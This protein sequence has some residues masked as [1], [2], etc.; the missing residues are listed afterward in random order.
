MIY[1]LNKI[2]EN[3]I[4]ENYKQIKA[5]CKENR[6][7]IF[8]RNE[9]GDTLLHLA[10]R[11]ENLDAVKKLMELGSCPILY[12]YSLITPINEAA[13]C[14]DL[15]I[16][17]YLVDKTNEILTDDEKAGVLAYAVADGKVENAKHL[18]KTGFKCNVLYND[19]PII[20]WAIQSGRLE[21]IELLSE[22]G[23]DLN[24]TDDS[25][26]TALYNACANG[27][28]D[29]V[30]FLLSK[31]VNINITS[32][33]G[34]SPLCIASC[35]NQIDIVKLLLKHNV[36]IEIM[37]ENGMTALLYAVKYENIEI[38][39]LLLKHGANPI[40]TDSKGRSWKGVEAFDQSWETDC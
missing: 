40:E 17:K 21:I 18:L 1:D 13:R 28:L 4:K 25:G 33:D 15:E 19:D 7:F 16:L 12:N 27:L 23:V 39:E 31:N 35:Y 3:M 29:I 9:E 2:Y 36:D 30:E 34:C 24:A 22:Y 38:A 26:F 14:D 6:N 20:L 8:A 5:L 11:N 37:D 32:N 10:V